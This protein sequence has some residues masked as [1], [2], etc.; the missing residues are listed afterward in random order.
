MLSD[1]RKRIT[2]RQAHE[3]KAHSCY[4]E[5]DLNRSFA[6][7]HSEG[8][9]HFPTSN[10]QSTRHSAGGRKYGSGY[11][12]PMLATNVYYAKENATIHLDILIPFPLMARII[13][14][15]RLV[16]VRLSDYNYM[17]KD[18]RKDG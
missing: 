4:A 10:F 2:R 11:P 13:H 5:F 16:I 7:F 9:G 14:G 15:E 12:L 18:C 3:E 17:D 8:L 1:C 6:P